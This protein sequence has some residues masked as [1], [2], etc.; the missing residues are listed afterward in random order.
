MSED[1]KPSQESHSL[2]WVL[3]AACDPCFQYQT[4]YHWGDR[5]GLQA[6]PKFGIATFHCIGID[7]APRY[8]FRAMAVNN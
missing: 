6:L 3:V 8:D 2:G 7:A 5:Y 1:S 4:G